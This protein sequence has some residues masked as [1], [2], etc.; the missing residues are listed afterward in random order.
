[1]KLKVKEKSKKNQKKNPLTAKYT[2]LS[3]RSQRSIE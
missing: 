2:K 3:Q 1:M